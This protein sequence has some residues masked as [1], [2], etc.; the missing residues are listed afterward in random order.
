MSVLQSALRRRRGE[1]G[2]ETGVEEYGNFKKRMKKDAK[3][4][5]AA[6]RKMVTKFE[7][8]QREN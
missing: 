7:D 2:I 6:L 4:L 8:R 5:I 1:P 3:R